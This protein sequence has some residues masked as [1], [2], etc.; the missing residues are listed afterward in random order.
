MLGAS[1]PGGTGCSGWLVPGSSSDLLALTNVRVRERAAEGWRSPRP[2][3]AVTEGKPVTLLLIVLLALLWGAVIVPTLLRARQSPASSVGAF[4]K[5][6]AALGSRASVR[7][8]RTNGSPAGR[9]IL[10]PPARRPRG[11]GYRS[12]AGPAAR[13]G[14]SVGSDLYAGALTLE[15]RRTI[16]FSLVAAAA[17]TLLLGLAYG[18]LLRLHLCIDIALAGYVVYLART[19]PRRV[20]KELITYHSPAMRR[21]LAPDGDQEREWLRAGEL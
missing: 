20:P 7:A 1:V 8:T 13:S 16:F 4:R 2:G 18:F 9:W 14:G 12:G 10:G 15:Q 5:N 3:V 19:K 6:M 17:F 21:G 11:R